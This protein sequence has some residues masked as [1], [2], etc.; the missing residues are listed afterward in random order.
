MRAMLFALAVSSGCGFTTNGGSNPGD[1][2][3]DVVP[4]DGC[5]T[6]SRQLDT[7]MSPTGVDQ[8]LQG[9][10]VLDTDAGTLVDDTDAMLSIT[11]MPV[12]TKTNS[13]EVLALFVG[14][15]TLDGTT[16]LRVVGSRP[17]AIISRG[18]V[19]LAAGA[20]IDLSAGGAGA[21]AMCSD[22]AAQPG[23]IDSGG[24]SGGGGGGFG[25]AGGN[26][27]N[28]DSDGGQSTGGTGGAAVTLPTG[29][30]GGCPGAGGGEGG[31]PGGA[32]ALG[33][34]A[35][36]IA[37]ATKIDIAATAG[38]NAGGGGGAGGAR[39]GGSFGD[40]GGG[41][42][43]SGGMIL[44]ESPLVRSAGI[45]AAN[46]GGGGEGSGNNDAGDPG[47][48]ALLTI[49][50]ALGGTGGS[51]TGTAGGVG[52]T[53]ATPPGGTPP[54]AQQGGGGGGGGSVGFIHV[55]STD[56]QLGTLVSPAAS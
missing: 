14:N 31:D 21:R 17:L 41:G 39:S 34:G 38:I 40:A 10:L 3:T 5:T 56:V 15:L 51:G 16:R 33:G 13:V 25:A 36:Y 18:T 22:N 2:S 48:K 43:G 24:A 54:G 7:C 53:V 11:T 46:G 12:M 47:D 28:G 20:V 23:A 1:A 8:A 42:G 27:G 35:I 29:P 37:A 49:E 9:V 4:V 55:D 50:P 26:G 52:G 6:F 45:L 32:G 44:F 19:T 30:L